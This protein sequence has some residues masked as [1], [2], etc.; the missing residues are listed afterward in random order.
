MALSANGIQATTQRSRTTSTSAE[1]IGQYMFDTKQPPVPTLKG[2][3]F[4][5]QLVGGVPGK[6]RTL[7]SSA[8]PIGNNSHAA[9]S[10]TTTNRNASAQSDWLAKY[11]LLQT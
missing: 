3:V 9:Q 1:F 7:Q 6:Q 5:M 11:W 8:K 4:T 10:A 2:S